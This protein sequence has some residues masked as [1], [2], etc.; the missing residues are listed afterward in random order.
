VSK[1]QLFYRFQ[2]RHN[3]TMMIADRCDQRREI[4]R[5]NSHNM[6]T[7]IRYSAQNCLGCE[8]PIE[9]EVPRAVPADLSPPPALR[10]KRPGGSSAHHEELRTTGTQGK[11]QV[12]GL[13]KASGQADTGNAAGVPGVQAPGQIATGAGPDTGQGAPAKASKMP[14]IN[15]APRGKKAQRHEAI[16]AASA[17]ESLPDRGSPAKSRTQKAAAARSAKAAS[18]RR[19]GVLV[20][21]RVKRLRQ[22]RLDQNWREADLAA[23]DVEDLASLLA[24][25]VGG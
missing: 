5:K 19:L 8:G 6:A 25:M 9:L 11:G 4:A 21:V 3:G 2:C 10:P 7:D 15:E 22:A 12:R 17:G 24:T 20:R 23:R 16:P 13:G 18:A 1:A 14:S